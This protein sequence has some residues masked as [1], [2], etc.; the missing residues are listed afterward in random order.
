MSYRERVSFVFLFLFIIVLLVYSNTFT[1]TWH[2]DDITSIVQNPRIHLDHI[3][4]SSLKDVVLPSTQ[5][6]PDDRPV[7]YLSFVL[8]WYFSQQNVFSYHLFNILIHIASSFLIFLI[9]LKCYE[10]KGLRRENRKSV[11]AIAL[12]S[13]LLWALNPIQ[14]QAV[15]YIV[16]R[17][18]SMAAL[19]Y[20]AGLWCY[21]TGRLKQEREKYF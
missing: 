5:E 17:M 6:A 2:F 20:L 11:F 10:T 4:V 18:A 7:A 9:I 15:T 1:A 21:L 8:N 14:T 12:L 13:T 16:Q 19:F 3:S